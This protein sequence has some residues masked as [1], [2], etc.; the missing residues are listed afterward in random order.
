MKQ[1]RS[2]FNLSKSTRLRLSAVKIQEQ[3]SVGFVRNLIK[4]YFTSRTHELIPGRDS[5]FSARL[6]PNGVFEYLKMLDRVLMGKQAQN[7]SK[8]REKMKSVVNLNLMNNFIAL[9]QMPGRKCLLKG[10]KSFGLKLTATHKAQMH[11]THAK[12][13]LLELPSDLSYT[14]LLAKADP[15]ETC[16]TCNTFHPA[17]VIL[18]RLSEPRAVS[19][20]LAKRILEQKP[21]G[22]SR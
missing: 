16:K 19:V 2:S 10:P 9:G 8:I 6:N 5:E 17:D 4:S 3:S 13:V 1:F 20:N 18:P 21:T 15:T 12:F 7:A 11:Q 22:N 14:K